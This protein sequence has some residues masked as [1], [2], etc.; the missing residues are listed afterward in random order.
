MLKKTLP[1]IV[2]LIISVSLGVNPFIF[3]AEE[4]EEIRICGALTITDLL[5]TP[6]K[7]A[8]EKVA[9]VRL[10][11]ISEEGSGKG[12][13][14]LIAGRCQ[15]AMISST[16]SVI[17]QELNKL[18]STFINLNDYRE[19]VVGVTETKFVIYP[20]N[21]VS[22]LTED[23]IKKILKGDISNWKEV[24][25]QD[26]PIKIFIPKIGDGVRATVQS[27]LLDEDQFSPTATVLKSPRET[28][29]WVGKTVGGISF[30]NFRLL[31][32]SVKFLTI[33][34]FE[35][36]QILTVVIKKDPSTKIK[37]VI[38]ELQKYGTKL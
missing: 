27:V 13:E 12:I 26:T 38:A 5:I 6:N 35:I 20:S 36:S 25:G 17:S 29:E 21:P 22:S 37:A 24:G 23:Q 8:I 9:N 1:R 15:I 33:K 34:D 3:A 7:A 28:Q 14:N 4:P 32:P 31:D 18:N 10:L 11:E 30:C 16:L 19:F 2:T